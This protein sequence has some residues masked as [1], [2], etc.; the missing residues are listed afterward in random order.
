MGDAALSRVLQGLLAGIGFLG[1]GA[2]LKI[3]DQGEIRGMTTAAG[4]W[5]TAGIG[6]AAGLGQEASAVLIT[7]FAWITLAILPRLERHRKPPNRP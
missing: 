7:L 2:I 1:A 5:L 6:V 3:S 4:I